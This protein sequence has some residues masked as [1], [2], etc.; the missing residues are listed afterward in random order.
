LQEHQYVTNALKE[1]RNI[2]TNKQYSKQKD[3]TCQVSFKIKV[4]LLE[5]AGEQRIIILRRIKAVF[6]FSKNVTNLGGT[7]WLLII[8]LFHQSNMIVHTNGNK[9]DVTY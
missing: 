7:R 8:L 6:L 3:P 4:F 9:I 1:C 2:R 5:H